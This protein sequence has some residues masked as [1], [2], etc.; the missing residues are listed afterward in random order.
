MSDSKSFYR[1]GMM[2]YLA[3]RRACGVP[4]LI[5]ID[6]VAGSIQLPVGVDT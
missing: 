6:F 3:T 1:S 5:Q 2:L 4:P